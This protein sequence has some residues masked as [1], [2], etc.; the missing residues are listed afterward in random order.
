MGA[1]DLLRRKV[2]TWHH[3]AARRQRGGLL[4]SLQLWGLFCLWLWLPRPYGPQR[5]ECLPASAA[6]DTAPM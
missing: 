5:H 2:F 6:A 4:L 3:S 1:G